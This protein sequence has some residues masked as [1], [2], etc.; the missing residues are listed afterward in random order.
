M[1]IKHL[2]L[3]FIDDDNLNLKINEIHCLLNAI[4]SSKRTFI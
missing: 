4:K 2:F 3:M 1:N